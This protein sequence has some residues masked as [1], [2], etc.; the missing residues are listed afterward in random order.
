LNFFAHAVVASWHS[1]D[2][3]FVL[4]AMLPDL[5]GM[6]GIRLHSAS[7]AEVQR[8]IQ[9]HYATDAAFHAAPIFTGLCAEAIARLTEQGVERGTARAVAH[10]GVELTL[11]GV[12]STEAERRALYAAALDVAVSGGL[13]GKL[14][15]TPQEDLPRLAA[16]LGRLARAS[17]PEAYADPEVVADRL[18]YILASRPRLAMRPSDFDPVRHWAAAVRPTVADRSHE[19]L[20]QVRRGVGGA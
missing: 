15:I 12:L 7:D 5:V 10:V 14:S 17:I 11:D 4:G 1:R 2:T 13:D 9:M 18:R 20:N 3:R 16:G 19:L 8:G 6:A